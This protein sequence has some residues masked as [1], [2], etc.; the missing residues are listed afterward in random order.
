MCCVLIADAM[1][2]LNGWFNTNL[3]MCVF[4]GFVT[5]L[6]DVTLKEVANP[7]KLEMKKPLNVD[8]DSIRTLNGLFNTNFSRG[9]CVYC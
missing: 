9:V 7:E 6:R 1:G 5:S 4:S 2:T 3:S 8:A